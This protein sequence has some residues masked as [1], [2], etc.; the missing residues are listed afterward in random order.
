[1]KSNRQYRGLTDA[2]VLQS[3]E[4]HGQNILTPPERESLL[5]KFL[6]KFSDPLIRIIMVAGILSVGIACYEYWSLDYDWQV[7]LIHC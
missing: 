2:E 3:R 7:L 5:R 1:M 4:Q 6:A